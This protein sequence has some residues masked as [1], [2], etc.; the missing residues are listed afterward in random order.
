[1]KRIAHWFMAVCFVG[2]LGAGLAASLLRSP[3][4]FSFW[5]NRMLASLPEPAPQSV[6][7]GGYFTQLERYLADHAPL[8]STLLRFKTR[9]DLALG[10]PVVN[11]VVVTSGSLLPFLPYMADDEQDIAHWAALMADNLADINAAVTEYGGYFCYAVVPCQSV[12]LADEYPWFLNSQA[13]RSQMKAAAMAQAMAERG[14]PYLDVEAVLAQSGGSAQYASRVDNHYTM[15]G[16]FA[17]YRLILEKAAADT[18]LRFP[19][20]GPDGFRHEILPNEYI[21]SRERK[22]LNLERREEQLSILLPN[23]PVPFTRADN[24]VTVDPVVYRL[25]SGGDEAVDYSLY[26]G[27]DIARTVIDTGRD[28]LPS[29]LIYGDSFT[30]PVE[31]L[32]Y[33]SFDETHS[34]DLRHYHDMGLLDYIRQFRPD[35]VVCIR[36]YDFMMATDGNGGGD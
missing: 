17:A 14:V 31:C 1:M 8:R 12:S 22:L 7:D 26:M 2:F 28:N 36:D 32:A 9:W 23:E 16:A 18:G 34:L 33:L 27:G 3:Q 29:I 13:R 15:E 11:D 20:L 19:I 21:G 10:R 4:D 35:I 30:N 24:G 5:E 25:P 6:G